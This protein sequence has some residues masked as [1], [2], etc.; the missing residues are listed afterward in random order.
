MSSHKKSHSGVSLTSDPSQVFDLLKKEFGAGNDCWTSEDRSRDGLPSFEPFEGDYADFTISDPETCRRITAW[1]GGHGA[2]GVTGDNVT[3]H[4][5]VKTTVGVCG[6]SFSMSNNQ[7]A[8]VSTRT[9]LC[10]AACYLD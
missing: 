5:E 10:E 4:I 2:V 8:L 7:V 6:E 1:L 3:Y 9:S